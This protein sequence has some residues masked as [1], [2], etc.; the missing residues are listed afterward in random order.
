MPQGVKVDYVLMDRLFR[1]KIY[2]QP[3]PQKT[4]KREEVQKAEY[5]RG[6]NHYHES[7][8]GKKLNI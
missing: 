2:S 4:W 3:D 1:R 7:G 5:S 6:R 8:D